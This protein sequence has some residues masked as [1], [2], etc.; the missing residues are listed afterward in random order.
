VGEG[1]GDLFG[2]GAD[3][4]DAL[5]AVVGKGWAKGKSA[6][7]VRGPSVAVFGTGEG[8]TELARRMDNRVGGEVIW[9]TVKAGPGRECEIGAPGT[10]DI[11]GDFGLGEDTVPE[12][13]RKV[14][15]GGRGN[16]DDVVFACPYS[17]LCRVGSVGLWWHKRHK[18]PLREK[19][20]SAL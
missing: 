20:L 5:A 10:H 7:P 12:V 14:R 4:I 9:K 13:V 17:L 16:G 19:V 15:V 11:E 8:K 18:Q 2:A 3:D 6:I 1:E